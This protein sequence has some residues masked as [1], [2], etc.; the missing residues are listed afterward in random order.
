MCLIAAP[1]PPRRRGYD[2]VNNFA[3]QHTFPLCRQPGRQ[4]IS[5]CAGLVGGFHGDDFKQK[6]MPGFRS[7]RAADRVESAVAERVIDIA[8]SVAGQ[9]RELDDGEEGAFDVLR[10][11]IQ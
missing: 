8:S 2:L 6:A 9:T 11:S 7:V 4:G 1:T 5:E 3:I 10:V